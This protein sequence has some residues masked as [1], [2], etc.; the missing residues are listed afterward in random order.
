MGDNEARLI[1]MRQLFFGNGPHFATNV[2]PRVPAP[3]YSLTARSMSAYG[4][5][6]PSQ[7]PRATC[8]KFTHHH[9]RG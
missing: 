7:F 1:S 3:I 2:A 6:W 4:S 5:S 8:T 9:S